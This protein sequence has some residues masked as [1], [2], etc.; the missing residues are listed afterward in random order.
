MTMEGLKCV[1]ASAVEG[2]SRMRRATAVSKMDVDLTNR[3]RAWLAAS[4]L[5]I[6]PT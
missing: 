3:A 6:V 1:A 4:K 5:T 2:K